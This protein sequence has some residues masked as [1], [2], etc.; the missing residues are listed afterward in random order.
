MLPRKL[1]AGEPSRFP[2]RVRIDCAWAIDASSRRSSSSSS[3]SRPT[4]AEARCT[5]SSIIAGNEI[6]VIHRPV[7]DD[8][9]PLR[10]PAGVAQR[11]AILLGPEEG[12][13]PVRLSRGPAYW[14]PRSGP[15]A[16][17]Q[18]NAPP[19]QARPSAGRDRRRCRRPHICRECWF[20][21]KHRPRPLPR[22][23]IPAEAAADVRGLTPIPTRTMS[24][25]TSTPSASEI[26]PL[27]KLSTVVPR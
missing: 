13:G 25:F 1:D 15:A 2:H 20:E 23:A 5:P 8:L 22:L 11:H 24:A 16:R 14:R 12:H 4:E 7:D 3:R 6:A 19:A 18:P 10:R 21:D 17:R 26:A 27:E 9:V